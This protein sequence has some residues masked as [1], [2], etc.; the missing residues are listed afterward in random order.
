MNRY[1]LAFLA[2]IVF[3]CNI[4]ELEFDNIKN[5]TFS[6]HIGIKLGSASYTI[7]ELVDDIEDAQLEIQ[8]GADFLLTFIYRDTSEFN[9]SN[10]FVNIGSI[11]NATTTGGGNTLPASPISFTLPISQTFTFDFEANDGELLD[12]VFYDSG[13]LDISLSSGFSGSFDLNFSILNTKDI[14][15]GLDLAGSISGNST[16]PGNFQRN[17]LGLKTIINN[18]SGKNEFQ[19]KIDG[20]IQIIAGS[21]VTPDQELS[22][23]LGFV[24]PGFSSIFGNFGNKSVEIANQTIDMAGF[25]EFGDTGLEFNAPKIILELDNSYG[26]GMGSTLSGVRAI[27]GDGSQINLTGDIVTNGVLIEGASNLNVGGT[28][29]SRIEIST[30]NS[31][32]ADLLNSTPNSMIFPVVA[33]LNPA[34]STLTTNFLT[35]SSKMVQRTIVEMPLDVKMEGF[36]RAFD[37]DLSDLDIDGASEMTLR[38]ITINEIPFSGTVTLQFLDAGGNSFHEVANN[39]IINSPTNLDSDGRTITPNQSVEDILLDQSGIDAFLDAKKIKVIMSI[40]SFDAASGTFIK[41]FS[42]YKL[43]I[44][45]SMSGKFSISID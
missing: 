36:S 40:E 1:I 15:T 21:P 11:Q 10:D 44:S 17:L 26:L 35:D 34:S 4:N 38:L 5:P 23:S 45:L 31:N 8:E 7:K 39:R 25:Q 30:A 14:S 16:T 6:P 9:V 3:S 41:I 22:I 12:S 32:I 29:T 20:Q 28:K 37:F 13:T 2:I 42:D 43:D 27:N 33:N 19:F 24:S 18:S